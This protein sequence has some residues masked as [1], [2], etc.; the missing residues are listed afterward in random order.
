ME[1]TSALSQKKVVSLQV[2]MK[3]LRSTYV[4]LMQ[5]IMAAVFG[6]CGE[7]TAVK[8]DNDR[9]LLSVGDSALRLSKVVARIPEGLSEADSTALFNSI[10][11]AWIQDML[12]TKVAAENIPDMD[13]LDRMVA[14]YRNRLIMMEYRKRMKED[15]RKSISDA[16]VKSYYEAHA[17]DMRLEHPVIKGIYIKV[18]SNAERIENVR[19]WVFSASK[20]SIDKLE[21]YGLKGAIQYDWFADRWVDWEIV[22]EQIP[23]R[24]YDADAFVESTVN[25][26]TVYNGSTYFLHISEY[27]KSGD[28]MPY[29]FATEQIRE[30]MSE[31]Y[32]RDSES[33]LMQSLFRKAIDDGS[34]KA[35][36]FDPVGHRM[37]PEMP[38]R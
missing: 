1:H 2:E 6:A 16:E 7:P 19:Q 34:L 10:V 23:Y 26:E 12:L 20:E 35:E 28:V 9:V 24:F 25:F 14:D 33:R 8:P 36:G 22:A 37:K 29:S 13:R 4:I 3:C 15:S 38:S 11:D 17:D 5:V 31:K 21:K 32:K 18:P 30:M 27:L